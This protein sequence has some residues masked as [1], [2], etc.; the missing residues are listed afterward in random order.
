MDVDGFSQLR[1]PDVSRTP[2]FWIASLES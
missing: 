2:L 1:L